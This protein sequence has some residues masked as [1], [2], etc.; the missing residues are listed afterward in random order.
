MYRI[1]SKDTNKYSNLCVILM[2][3]SDSNLCWFP[4]E[5]YSNNN[6]I[7]YNL[8]ATRMPIEMDSVKQMAPHKLRHLNI[9]LISEN[10]DDNT[11]DIITK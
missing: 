1:K 3:N 11:K 5:T 9:N 2:I 7:E 10:D 8:L 6:K 4:S